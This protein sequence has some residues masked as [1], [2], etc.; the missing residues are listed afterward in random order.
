[1][2]NVNLMGRL[3]AKPEL[4]KANEKSVTDFTIAIKRAY[5]DKSDFIRCTAWGSRAEVITKYLDKGAPIAVTGEWQTD[6]WEDANGVKHYS[7]TCLV[8]N[9]YFVP[10]DKRDVTKPVDTTAS[11]Y[12]TG[13]PAPTPTPFD[14]RY[15]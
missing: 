4:R 1:M 2:N 7:N 8:T 15:L 12:T 14:S 5:G 9:F 3:T 6:T 11:P 10:R 13:M